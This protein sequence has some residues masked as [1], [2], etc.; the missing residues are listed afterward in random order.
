M[1]HLA[2]LVAVLLVAAACA[3]PTPTRERFNELFA[4]NVGRGIDGDRYSSFCSIK[5]TE[6]LVN[7]RRLSNGN[8]RYRFSPRA[9]AKDGPCTYNCDVD[10]SSRTVV[11]RSK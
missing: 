11:A 10:P 6:S 8:D 1:P 4:N 3:D 7:V 2:L 9:A 5:R